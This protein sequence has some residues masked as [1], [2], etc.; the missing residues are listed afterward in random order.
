MAEGV[1]MHSESRAQPDQLASSR[2]LAGDPFVYLEADGRRMLAVGTFEAHR[3]AQESQADEVWSFGDLGVSDLYAEGLDSRAVESEL[4]LRAARRAGLD[5]VIVPGWFP[6]ATAEHLRARGVAVRI[7]DALFEQRR[8]R[9]DAHAIAAI[10]EITAVVEDS[11]GLIRRHLAACTIDPDGTLRDA[12]GV[13]TSERL[14][15]AVRVFWAENGLEGELPIIA[16]GFHGADP[17]DNGSGPLLART[18]IICDL[19]PRSART[20]YHGDMTRT[21]C[22]G[23][24][25]AELVELHVTVE[26][27]LDTALGAIRPGVRGSSLDAL[28][29]DL[30][31]Q[32]GH[33][34]TRSPEGVDPSSVASYIHGLGHGVG[35][36][37]HEGPSI[38]RGGNQDLCAGDVVT[39]EPGLYRDGFGGVRI[40]EIVV[41]T[42]NGCENL[43]RFDRSLAVVV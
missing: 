34:T 30:F 31:E 10:R 27:A 23:E 12:D 5:R 14:H 18:P 25:P 22:V 24:P 21:F 17:H 40:E 35:L 9:K 2:F 42:E 16:G 6:L 36:A 41:V 26:R 29:C 13:L 43:N 11:M 38:G 7:D 1:M 32:A 39:V 19:F 37:I 4:A 28:V 3:A 33:P 8:R 15:A 20:C